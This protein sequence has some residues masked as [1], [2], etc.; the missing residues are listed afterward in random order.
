MTR[1][2]TPLTKDQHIVF[3]DGLCGFCDQAVQFLLQIDRRQTLR[4][5]P[6]QGPTAAYYLS[7]SLREDLSTIVFLT[8]ANAVQKST[9]ILSIL[10][11]VGGLWKLTGLFFLI[12]RFIRDFAYT[13]IATNRYR[14]FGR[15]DTCRRPRPSE[16][17]RFL[18]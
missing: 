13:L 9:A 2:K 14:W 5:A 12:P 15:L 16:K 7:P 8:P 17:A 6:L 3:Y 1:T 18:D 11:T 4:F 10:W